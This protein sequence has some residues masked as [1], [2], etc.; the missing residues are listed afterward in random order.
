MDTDRNLLFAVLVLQADLIDREHFIQ[1]CTLWAARKDRPIAELL[2]EQG[3]LT[4]AHR[5]VV[6]QLIEAK[7]RK[8]GSDVQAS[9]AEAAGPQARSALASISDAEVEHSLA[10]LPA[11]ADWPAGAEDFSTVPPADSA[12]RNLLYEEIGRGGIGRVLRGHDPELRRDLAVKVLRDEYRDDANVQRRFVEEAQVGGQLQHPGVVPV[13][14][15]G[16]FPDRRPYFT[17]KLVKGRTLAELLKERPDAGHDLSRFLTVFEQVC[18]TVAYAHSKGVIHRDLKPSNVMVGAFGEVQVM[19][20]GL[21]KVLRQQPADDPETTTARTLIRTARSD[22]T[23]DEDG[24]TGVVGTPA[25]MAPEQA[26]GDTDAVDER[27]DVFGLG[28]ILCVLLTGQPPFADASREEVLRSATAGE[29]GEAFVR[30]DECGADAE[31]VAVCKACLA[32][33]REDRPCDAGAVAARMAAY[34]AAVQERLRAAELDR[35]TAAA[36]AREEEAKA[37]AAAE[38]R[39][40]RLAL[41]LAAALVVGIMATGYFLFLARVEKG[42]AEDL[43]GR[44][45]EARK[46]AEGLSDLARAAR[47]RAE[48]AE[49][50][51]RKQMY[52]TATS[53]AW[54]AFDEGNFRLAIDLLGDYLPEPGKGDL[55]RV[56]WYCLLRLC[57]RGRPIERDSPLTLPAREDMIRSVAFSPDGATVA[58]ADDGGKVQLWD[59]RARKEREPLA[60]GGR[61]AAVAFSPDPQANTLACAVWDENWQDV[62]GSP[63]GKVLRRG[64]PSGK[65][66]LHDLTGKPRRVLELSKI[67]YKMQFPSPALLPGGGTALAFSPDGKTLALGVGQFYPDLKRNTGH[68][69]LVDV[70]RLEALRVIPVPEHLVL[71]LAFSPDGKGLAAGTWKKE[72]GGSSGRVLRW[73]VATGGALAPLDGHKGGVTGVA[74]SRDGKW[75]ASSSWDRTVK[76]WDAAA[77]RERTTLSGHL[78]RVWSVAFSPAFDGDRLAS[79]STDGTVRLWDLSAGGESLTLR[80][81]TSSVYSLAFSPDGKTLASGSWDRTVKLWDMDVERARVSPL[82]HDDWVYCLAFSPD[83]KRLAS[84]G[85][86]TKVR[87]WDVATRRDLLRPAGR[88]GPQWYKRPVLSVAFSPDGKM[89]ASGSWDMT[90]R[91][92]DVDAGTGRALGTHRGWVRPVAFSPDGKALASGSEDGAVK[93]WDV[94]TGKELN[95]FN[96]GDSVNALAFSPDGRSLAVG[97]GDR[98][99]RPRG[100]VALWDLGTWKERARLDAADGGAVTAL[101]FSPDG[102][103]LAFWSARFVTHDP[104]PGELQLWDLAGEPR[105]PGAQPSVRPIQRHVGSASSLAFSPDGR[106]VAS[107]AGDQAVKLWDVETGEECAT[108]KG[109]TDRVMAVA[110]SPDGRTLATGSLDYTVRL[111]ESATDQDVIDFFDRLGGQ[112]PQETNWQIDRAL[113]CWG[114]YLHADRGTADGRAAAR[115]RLEKGL[116][117]LKGL[118]PDGRRLTEDKQK[119]WVAEF[120]KALAEL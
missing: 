21:A 93:L 43:A 11:A 45:A 102:K 35:A 7:L 65:V 117:I 68:V 4:P 19:D 84:G 39:S 74:F 14:E 62:A 64:G 85:W 31:L 91:L 100:R 69:V 116:Q 44:E 17:M 42:K 3:W 113:A 32:P 49:G 51:T 55:R 82:Q 89:L 30:L 92:W 58:A 114:Y 67:P 18:Q 5:S 86:D 87:V 96:M 6:E 50:Q 54:S 101:A 108:L 1:A 70:A 79:G 10:A 115:E 27:A 71:S 61:V 119:A 38:R 59:V 109:H 28:A 2:V 103:R 26:R 112:E 80:G 94:A 107:G 20:W 25:Y 52:R 66:L 37:T 99:T 47:D 77:G 46:E 13:Y 83:G 34:Q 120:E 63:S 97:T 106:T 12:G 110:F 22:S 75:L 36:K 76:V 78:N 23:A 73:D 16:H 24:R 9:L 98:Y 8:H 57:S 81:H 105:G 90:V 111:W 104:I 15:L 29:M 53:H 48:L 56:E 88:E 33:R 60:C 40:R 41:G 72:L 118:S 95:I